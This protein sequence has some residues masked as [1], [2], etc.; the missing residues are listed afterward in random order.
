MGTSTSKNDD[1]ENKKKTLNQSETIT[2][3]TRL[4]SIKIPILSKIW[5]KTYNIEET[6]E[7]VAKDFTEENDMDFLDDNYY[8][9]W[10]YNNQE[11]KMDDTKIKNFME[12]NQIN[13]SSPIEIHQEI[14]PVPGNENINNLDI[15]YEI[16]G[17]PFFNPFEIFTYDITNKKIKF[18]KFQKKIINESQ[19]DKFGVESAYCNGNNHL[20][21]SGGSSITRESLDLFWDFDLKEI[22]NNNN[23]NLNV[24]TKIIPKK[25][26]SMIYY[27]N[28]VFLVGGD[29][30]NTIYV[31]TENKNVHD[32]P[33]LNMKRFEPSLIKFNN[34]IYCFDSTKK[35]NNDKYS[36][37]R[38]NLEKIENQDDKENKIDE[39]DNDKWEII[40]PD[41]SP[42]LG[43]N[44]YN[45]KFFGIA[46]DYK[47]NIIFLGGIYD[48][49]RMLKND[50]NE[51]ENKEIM[52]TR[53]NTKKNMMEL[54]DVPY[55]EIQLSEKTFLCLE[56]NNFFVLP[57]FSKRAPKLVN[58]FRDRDTLKISSY[59]SS[60]SISTSSNNNNNNDVG[61]KKKKNYNYFLKIST[62]MKNSL[63]GLNFDM[64]MTH[65]ENG[66]NK[67][68]F[69][70]NNDKILVNNYNTN[71]NMRNNNMNQEVKLNAGI[72]FDNKMPIN[73]T[74][75][76]SPTI[77]TNI[78]QNLNENNINSN[79]DNSN[80]ININMNTKIEEM[81][82][83]NI[84]INNNEN[85]SNNDKDKENNKNDD[86]NINVNN[87]INNKIDNDIVLKVENNNKND[88]EEKNSENNKKDGDGGEIN[89][90]DYNE[91]NTL[92]PIAKTERT[93]I[94]N[95]SDRTNF[96]NSVD[97]PC[98]TIRITKIRN[99]PYPDNIPLKK[100]KM[101][102]RE[103][104]R[105]D[106]NEIRPNN[107]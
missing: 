68:N 29:N 91:N 89:K 3:T 73:S 76:N 14:K 107:Y 90:D 50:G 60:T 6:L 28:K 86:I 56:H 27:N 53:Y 104:L 36:L 57:N 9:V 8:I 82:I 45:Q 2:A 16:V 37:E 1:K 44:V 49:S 106:N 21:I 94:F 63:L 43:N 18:I 103:L 30:E 64:P 20:Y 39:Q 42:Q 61:K 52:S 77:G 88:E 34:Y 92:I 11:I 17:K 41:I 69:N 96:H 32:L 85:I 100:I 46:E 97:D 24:A 33:N 95:K 101:R 81:D 84:K 65:K 25:N 40:Y 13:D 72:N 48:N 70:Y 66:P 23:N 67:I 19:L 78:K 99:R 93:F 10:T 31:D 5:E 79:M 102:A 74:N 58:F 54:S 98:S 59:K 51:K 7:K 15:E 4:T 55:Q 22:K 105:L 83:N 38:L 35:I 12:D 26:H 71:L 87:D 80:N 75:I 47:K 62:Q